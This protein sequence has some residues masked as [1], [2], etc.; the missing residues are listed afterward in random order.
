MHRV[1]SAVNASISK[2]E[3]AKDFSYPKNRQF[4]L[5]RASQNLKKFDA[6]KIRLSLDALTSAD[7]SI[8]TFGNDPYATLEQLT[9][10]L[11]YILTKGEAVD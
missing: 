1:M 7:K 5:D 4:L 10:K 8:K 6:K 9:V 3:I 2:D 11:V